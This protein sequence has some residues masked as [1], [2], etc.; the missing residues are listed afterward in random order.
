MKSL[1]LKGKKYV[2]RVNTANMTNL[3][4]KSKKEPINEPILTNYLSNKY[5]SE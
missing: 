2:K 3:F 4:D 1:N 5:L